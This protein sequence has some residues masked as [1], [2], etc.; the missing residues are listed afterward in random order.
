MAGFLIAA[1]TLRPHYTRSLGP[2]ALIYGVFKG[3]NSPGTAE[4]G[5]TGALPQPTS[6]HRVATMLD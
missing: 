2:R 1:E 6:Y 5:S 3:V 4:E